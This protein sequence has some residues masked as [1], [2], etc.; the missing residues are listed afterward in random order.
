MPYWD[1]KKAIG[2]FAGGF[3][4]SRGTNYSPRGVPLGLPAFPSWL[5]IFLI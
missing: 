3:F 2:V 1:H 4:G 5:C